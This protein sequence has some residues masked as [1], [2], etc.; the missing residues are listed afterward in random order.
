MPYIHEYHDERYGDCQDIVFII[1]SGRES[2]ELLVS[3]SDN[4]RSKIETPDG[5]KDFIINNCFRNNSR[6][7]ESQNDE[8]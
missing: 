1:S 7:I 4:L 3:I 6:A 8:N 5:L 2:F